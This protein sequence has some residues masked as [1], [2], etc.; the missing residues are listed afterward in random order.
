M[1]TPNWAPVTLREDEATITVLTFERERGDSRSHFID[2]CGWATAEYREIS[3]YYWVC[4]CVTSYKKCNCCDHR[5]EIGSAYLGKCC[6][7]NLG[8]LLGD[9]KNDMVTAI[10]GYAPQLVA[11]SMEA[12][13]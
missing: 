10:S 9:Y 1:K 8:E 4:V 2:F 12:G 5:T 7:K 6:Y 11:E 13:E 3:E